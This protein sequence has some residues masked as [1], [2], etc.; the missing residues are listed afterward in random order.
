MH[1]ATR[2]YSPPR[3]D[4]PGHGSTSLKQNSM[5]DRS[6]KS[7]EPSRRI[8]RRGIAAPPYADPGDAGLT[9]RTIAPIR[10]NEGMPTKARA[11]SPGKV[12]ATPELSHIDAAAIAHPALQW[13]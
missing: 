7:N 13:N 1:A 5:K 2:P 10:H 9:R 6:L 11:A 12:S 4:S 8:T 3:D